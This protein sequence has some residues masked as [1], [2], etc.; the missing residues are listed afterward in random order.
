MA[1][2]H[3]PVRL[4]HGTTSKAATSILTKGVQ[5]SYCSPFTDFGRGFYTTTWVQQAWRWARILSGINP[6]L[7]PAVIA[8]DVNRR[9]LGQREHLFFT[10]ESDR[11]TH[12]WRSSA[13][14]AAGTRRMCP[15][16]LTTPSFQ[17]RLLP[18]HLRPG[19]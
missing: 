7:R 5:L 12:Y 19:P 18:G 13:T 9:T 16:G 6:S 15:A 1:W 2:T 17:A 11:R 3:S 4:Y 10:H 8:F 14:A